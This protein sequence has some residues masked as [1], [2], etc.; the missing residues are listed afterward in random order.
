MAVLQGVQISFDELFAYSKLKELLS[1]V[2][3][4]LN[5]QDSTLK[6][7]R[8]EKELILTRLASTEEK[9]KSVDQRAGLLAQ[10]LQKTGSWE[11]RVAD[12]HTELLRQQ[13]VQKQAEAAAKAQHEK[14]N[15]LLAERLKAESQMSESLQVVAAD[16]AELRREL[17][18]IQD[19]LAATAEADQKY[20]VAAHPDDCAL[21]Q[22][23]ASATDCRDA[24]RTAQSPLGKSCSDSDDG[25]DE[26]FESDGEVLLN[27][28]EGQADARPQRAAVGADLIPIPRT[29]DTTA[30]ADD[31]SVVLPLLEKLT[32]DKK[33]VTTPGRDV[34]LPE[35]KFTER[36][37]V[38][39]VRSM[40][41]SK[42][43]FDV[44][45]GPNGIVSI[46]KTYPGFLA[47]QSGQIF[48]GDTLLS[49]NG[50]PLSVHQLH[51]ENGLAW[52]QNLMNR[53]KELEVVILEVCSKF[54][55]QPAAKE[56]AV[57]RDCQ[58]AAQEVH[59]SEAAK[60]EAREQTGTTIASGCKDVAP[61]EVQRRPAD[62]VVPGRK[63]VAE[64]ESSR[65]PD[66][67][68]KSEEAAEAEFVE[69]H[70]EGT[71]ETAVENAAE[72]I[73]CSRAAMSATRNEAAEELSC[74]KAN[75]SASSSDEAISES[76]HSSRCSRASEVYAAARMKSAE[77]LS[78]SEDEES[79]PLPLE[80]VAR[81]RV[82]T[83][84]SS[85]APPPRAGMQASTATCSFAPPLRASPQAVDLASSASASRAETATSAS[86]PRSLPDAPS[87]TQQTL[88]VGA[89]RALSQAAD[90]ATNAS[91][92]R[93]LSGA[94]SE[95][96]QMLE[97]GARRRPTSVGNLSLTAL[98]DAPHAMKDSVRFGSI[99]QASGA[100]SARSS[101]TSSEADSF[102]SDVVTDSPSGSCSE[103]QSP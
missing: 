10:D 66:E 16:A 19:A 63:L 23:V 25:Y 8:A 43:G 87:E 31:A 36:R 5:E 39:L 14:T 93:S 75:D 47:A 59:C 28:L 88:E 100:M 82:E 52:K 49:L 94:P 48:V 21:K 41:N 32:L 46:T 69:I 6:T 42:L 62:E 58:A 64:A 77:S 71:R 61:E 96:Q 44:D 67:E 20:K 73:D 11:Q 56:I 22:P 101:G 33:P 97:V 92:P 79:L 57:A 55:S 2:V 74:E 51:G 99:Q 4:Q 45:E 7:L 89:R 86:A 3:T 102:V 76:L 53:L 12:I 18:K 27:D 83:T 78:C 17:A 60:H 85:F 26:S 103:A 72:Y 80:Q 98:S 15:G 54:P 37:C 50:E 29:R 95:A 91:A 40:A 1:L 90:L 34:V 68:T 9:L 35:K 24:R 30:D 70:K 38:K 65:R 81:A 13:F 84:A